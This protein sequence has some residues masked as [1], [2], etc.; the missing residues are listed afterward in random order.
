[1]KNPYSI[2]CIIFGLPIMSQNSSSLKAHKQDLAQVALNSVFAKETSLEAW[3][4]NCT[5]YS[6]YI[7]DISQ[8]PEV[9]EQTKHFAFFL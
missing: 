6:T 9:P 4:N 2:Y 1:M 5:N 8:W 7:L 3:E